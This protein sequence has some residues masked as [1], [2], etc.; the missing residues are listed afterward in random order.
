M[1]KCICIKFDQYHLK[2]PEFKGW[3]SLDFSLV[4]NPD[5][6]QLSFKK[7]SFF[8]PIAVILSIG[9]FKLKETVKNFHDAY[10]KKDCCD[11]PDMACM[12]D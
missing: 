11:K 10:H 5:P 1:H 7:H 8:T 6:S 4:F 3:E 12:T 9:L 2:N